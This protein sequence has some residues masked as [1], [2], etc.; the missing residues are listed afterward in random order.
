[1]RVSDRYGLRGERIWYGTL[2]LTWW[3]PRNLPVQTNPGLERN[4]KSK[5][6]RDGS[7]WVPHQL[8]HEAALELPDAVECE[9]SDH[10]LSCKSLNKRQGFRRSTLQCNLLSSRLPTKDLSESS[11]G[12][13]INMFPF[14]LFISHTQPGSSFWKALGKQKYLDPFSIGFLKKKKKI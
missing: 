10:P 2:S 5:R 9:C 11:R 12:D 13:T 4:N 3:H 1:M 8:T 7:P 6:C 14:K